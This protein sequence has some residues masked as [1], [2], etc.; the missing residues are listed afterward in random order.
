MFQLFKNWASEI[1]KNIY[2]LYIASKNPKVPFFAKILI[3]LVIAY[4]M[5]PIDLIPDFIPVIGYLDDLLI[6]PIGIWLSIKVIPKEVWQSCQVEAQSKQEQLSNNW[7][8]GVIIVFIWLT[9]IAISLIW[10]SKFPG[11]R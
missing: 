10:F 8:A 3:V 11:I 2:A 4:A 9:L 6:L 1:K 5:S 7:I